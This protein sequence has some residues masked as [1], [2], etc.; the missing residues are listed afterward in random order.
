MATNPKIYLD[1]QGRQIPLPGAKVTR[2]LNKNL[3][4]IKLPYFENSGTGGTVGRDLLRVEGTFTIEGEWEDDPTSKYDGWPAF[5]RYQLMCAIAKKKR[6]TVSFVW[7]GYTYSCVI[8]NFTTVKHSGE[9]N[10]MKYS[11]SLVR[12]TDEAV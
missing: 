9:G 5:G 2:R 1:V 8:K 4:L 10:D 3:V 6:V 11:I 12:V 7:L